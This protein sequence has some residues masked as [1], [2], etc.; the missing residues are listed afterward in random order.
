MNT[1]FLSLL[2]EKENDFSKGQKRIARY[3]RESY[4][5]AAFMTA[6]RTTV[7]SDTPTV[8]PRRFAVIKAALS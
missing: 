8:L 6:K 3:I 5:K 4:D 2:Q 1:D 7:D